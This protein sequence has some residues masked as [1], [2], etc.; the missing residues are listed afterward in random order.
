MEEIVWAFN[1]LKRKAAT[2]KDGLSAEMTNRNTLWK[3]WHGLLNTCWKKGMVPTIWGESILVPVQKKKGK[4]PCVADDFRGIS[5]L[6]VVY[7]AIIQERLS[8][9]CE[10]YNL[11]AEEQGGFRRGRECRDQILSLYLL[12]QLKVAERS[13]GVCLEHSL[14]SARPMTGLINSNSGGS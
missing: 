6:S 7:K 4:G 9:L 13:I 5:L 12:G 3:L 2:G 14:I 8:L 1:N 10:G 11:I